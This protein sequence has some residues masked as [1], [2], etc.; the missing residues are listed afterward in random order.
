MT[1][2]TRRTVLAGTA[3]ALVLG[4]G[5][6][7]DDNGDADDTGGE[8]DGGSGDDG[9]DGNGPDEASVPSADWATEHATAGDGVA[10]YRIVP[11]RDES[12]PDDPEA[13]A[14]SS[15]ADAEEW[16]ED[17]DPTT[18]EESLETLID[19]TDFD[20]SVLVVLEARG[21]TL[22]KHLAVEDVTVS[23][24]G[25]P[26]ITGAVTDYDDAGEYCAQQVVAVGAAVRVTPEGDAVADSGS[27][28]IVDEDGN[29]H[30][31]EWGGE[32]L[33]DE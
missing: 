1:R 7:S 8:D 18:D 28:T 33:P 4:A 17:R 2:H 14:F 24:A 20:E 30:A 6:L 5:C 21:S 3:T 22:C 10:D 26:A 13:V 23:D 11:Y 31:I 12:Y 9:N 25:E 29:E 27:A 15:A 19:E 32:D 16:L